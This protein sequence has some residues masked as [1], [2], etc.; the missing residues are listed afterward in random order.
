M[1]ETPLDTSALVNTPATLIGVP[2]NLGA[3]NMGVEMGPNAYR[4][5]DIVAKLGRAG[6]DVHDAGN[7]FCDERWNVSRSDNPKLHYLQEILRVSE[8]TAKLTETAVRD[9]RKAIVL[10]G[11]HSICLGAVSGAS[12]ALQGQSLGLIYFDAHGDMCTAETTPSGNIHGMQL[13]SLMGFGAAELAQVH[14]EQVKVVPANVLHIGGSDFDQ[15]ELDLIKQENLQAFTLDDML[16]GGMAPVFPLIDA[17]AARVDN[18]W[19]SLDLDCIDVQYAPA[20]GMPNSKGLLYREIKTLAT[21]VGQ[22]CNVVGI[23]VVEYNPL[24]DI[25]RKTAS[26]A[27]ELIA[28]FLG[29]E[30]SWYTEYLARNPA[31]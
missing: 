29:H 23:D 27:T 14:G 1:N 7:V 30:Y 20:A 25:E 26:L 6:L 10:G 24:N 13:A 17:L 8:D 2:L 12:S 16:R 31:S 28:N 11:D 19:I 22:H 18:V 21:Y 9:G 5:Q 4:W 3:N 15:A